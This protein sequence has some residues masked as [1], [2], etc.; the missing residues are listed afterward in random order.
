[1]KRYTLAEL[2]AMPTIS[3][4]HMEDLKIEVENIKVW[5]SRMTVEDGMP[6]NN[7]V[8]VENYDT[9]N[10]RWETVAEYQAK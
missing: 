9:I 2:E 3:Q 6:Y 8:T 5:L 10:G 1:M 4:G 7:Q